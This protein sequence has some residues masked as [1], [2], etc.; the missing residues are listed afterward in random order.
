MGFDP[1]KALAITC[2]GDDRSGI[3]VSLAGELDLATAPRLREVLL[4]ILSDGT[5]EPPHLPPNVLVVDLSELEMLSAA[6]LTVL[7]EVHQIGAQ[8]GIRL[9]IVTGTRP[10][11]SR[12]ILHMSGL[13]S[14]FDVYPSLP[15]A[16]EP[17][18]PL[19]EP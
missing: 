17:M 5:I 11:L 3:V 19:G 10:S 12:R 13:E 6:G 7:Y 18:P 9:R 8:A 2:S 14:V 16:R 4:A 1:A 15:A